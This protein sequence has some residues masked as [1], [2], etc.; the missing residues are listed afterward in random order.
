[1]ADNL[2][3]GTLLLEIGKGLA[4]E[5]TVDL[6]TVDKGG[7]GDEAVGLDILVK[8]VRGGLVEDDGV[9]GLVLDCILVSHRY[10]TS[11]VRYVGDAVRR[12]MEQRRI[13]GTTLDKYSCAC[14]VGKPT[15]CVYVC[16]CWT[17]KMCGVHIPFPLDHFFFCFLPPVAAGAWNKSVLSL[18]DYTQ[19]SQLHTILSD[20]VDVM[21]QVSW[22]SLESQNAR[23]R[24][25]RAKTR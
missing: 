19:G 6:E 20:V 9:L 3:D 13:S 25:W 18:S 22:V 1:M 23:V 2:L 21:G 5:R 8:L 7:D 17:S 16:A 24:K 11:S 4:G 12:G 10:S 15:L 14:S